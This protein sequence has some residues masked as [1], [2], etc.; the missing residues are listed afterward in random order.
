MHVS[1]VADVKLLL[2]ATPWQLFNRPSIQLGALKAFM[3]KEVPG[4]E[5]Q[6]LHPYLSYAARLG[7]PDYHIISQSSWASEAVGASMLCDEE[8]TIE[9]CREVFCDALKRR[10][11]GARLSNAGLSDLFHKARHL[12]S[13]HL[14]EF[15][16]CLRGDG[17]KLAGFTACL[18][19]FAASLYAARLF[20]RRFPNV[21]VVLGGTSCSGT[22]APSLL[23]SFPQ[24]DY[25]IS[26]EGELPLLALYKHLTEG[27]AGETSDDALPRAV[28]SRDRIDGTDPA[29]GES[30]E[31]RQGFMLQV[32]SMDE[33]PVPDFDD[34]F[35]ELGELPASERFHP[36]LPVEAS[37]GC[38]WG[39]CRFCNLNLQWRGYRA[40][41]V[42]KVAKDID[43]LASRYRC[44]DFAFM[45]NV[46]PRRQAAALFEKLAQH[47]R[48]YRIFAELRAVHSRAEY[49]VMAAGGLKTLQ[50]GIEALSDSLLKRLGKG[51]SVIANIAAMRHAFEAGIE[52]DANLIVHFP[53]STEEEAGESLKILEFVWPYRPLRTVSFWLGHGSP[54]EQE[55]RSLGIGR[56]APHLLWKKLFYCGTISPSSLI[57]TYSGD[58][59]VQKRRW[60]AVETR[61]LEM[62]KRRKALGL[63]R[64]LLSYRD[65]REF[66]TINQIFADETSRKHRLNG[67]SREIYLFC[68]DVKT[69]QEVM[70]MAEGRISIEQLGRFVQ[71]MVSQRLMFSDGKKVLSLAVRER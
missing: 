62:R 44:I 66:L 6:A 39:R 26:G 61:V 33:L 8:G 42:S 21:P 53:G 48:D 5:V 1:Q 68:L 41:S 50:V 35:R 2:V 59:K 49:E 19:Q 65:G 16:E 47:N 15:T 25:V 43:R 27:K 56:I 9:R 12:F 36:V 32:S 13:E 60:R 3:Q 11:A 30:L 17:L 38:W 57:L 58:R 7:F 64:Q 45:D 22:I 63:D 67:L 28:F 37:R 14:Q 55:S 54:A 4:L 51:S 40:A 20:K 23:A 46:L 10:G 52:L 31:A 24:I 34:Y 29:G 70:E 18:N 71:N 69:V